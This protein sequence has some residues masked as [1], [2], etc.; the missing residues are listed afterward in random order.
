MPRNPE[1]GFG[2]SGSDRLREGSRVVLHSCAGGRKPPPKFDVRISFVACSPRSSRFRT[3]TVP[4]GDNRI[5]IGQ[6]ADTVIASEVV[7]GAAACEKPPASLGASAPAGPATSAEGDETV[8][9]VPDQTAEIV[10][11]TTSRPAGAGV[12]VRAP[13][14]LHFGFLDLNGGLGRRFGSIGLAL[15][16]PAVQL[17]A[18]PAKR[19]SASGPEAERVR[20]NLLAAAAYLD[21]PEA[22]AV[23]IEESIPA[24]AG[25]GSGT[26]LALAVAAALARLNGRPFAPADF[27]DVL[28][29]GNR[30]G[31]GL[32]A[33]TEGG[34]I[35]DGGRDGSGAPPPVIARLPYPGDWRVV[36]ILDEAMTGVHGSRETEAFRDLPPFDAGQAA[37]ICRI[38][39]MQVLPAA[40]TAEPNGFGAG[41]TAIQ[42]RIGD[43]FAPHQ[44]GRFASPAVADALAAIAQAGVPGYGQSSWGPTGFALVPSQ[45]EAETLVAGL[46]RPGRLRF[47]IARGR[48]VGASVAEV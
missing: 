30:S 10:S 45:K 8:A 11:T 40:A 23:E 48:N 9:E 28:D 26:Q 6:D 47:V 18:R 27:A 17:V 43:H 42:K 46:A 34:L 5:G 44:G 4:R 14:R 36:L 33:F 39:L 24:H 7:A 16:A 35:V 12:R 13:A 41:I 37:E 32:A 19:V 31:V 22:V 20:A 2:G 38:V 25:F 1:C 21:V 15:D 3:K 29:R